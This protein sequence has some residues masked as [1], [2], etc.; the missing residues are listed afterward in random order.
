MANPVNELLKAIHARLVGDAGLLAVIGA[1][2]IRD[3]RIAGLPLPAL[4]IGEAEM[5][6]FSTASEDGVE[7]LLT[8]EA[9]SKVG[10]REAEE[11]AG[12]VRRLLHDAT[13]DVA[14]HALV[15]LVH[16]ASVSR[17]EPK[18]TLFVAEVRFR[19]VLEPL[20]SAG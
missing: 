14:G 8:L 13:L 15:S 11:I 16:R 12:A 10:R 9:W 3:R 19:A 2:G 6:D 18:T 4:V 1:D 7:I 20:A 17:R 5:R